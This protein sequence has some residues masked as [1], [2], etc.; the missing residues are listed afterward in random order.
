MTVQLLEYKFCICLAANVASDWEECHISVTFFLVFVFVFCIFS[1]HET[2]LSIITEGV[3]N[4][5]LNSTRSLAHLSSPTTSLRFF[6]LIEGLR[7]ESCF[8]LLGIFAFF[9]TFFLSVFLQ[10]FNNIKDYWEAL[11]LTTSL[12]REMFSLSF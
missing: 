7:W 10:S 9:F 6:H 5:N 4:I 12:A 3:L 11:Q 1:W 8:S 2:F